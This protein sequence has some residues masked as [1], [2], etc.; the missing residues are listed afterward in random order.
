MHIKTT[1][2]IVGISRQQLEEIISSIFHW[3]WSTGKFY[4]SFSSCFMCTHVSGNQ[5]IFLPRKIVT[6]FALLACVF[7]TLTVFMQ[8]WYGATTYSILQKSLFW[9][10]AAGLL[11][12][13][14]ITGL[15]KFSLEQGNC[16][17]SS[18]CNT[19]GRYN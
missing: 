1:D 5:K 17:N 15:Q 18:Y 13:N 19:G 7:K 4:F 16:L 8:S 2:K 12:Q 14:N 3:P 11:A 6:F 10:K 9:L